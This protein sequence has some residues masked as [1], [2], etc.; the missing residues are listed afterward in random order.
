MIRRDEPIQ[1]MTLGNMR[2]NGVR[3]LYVTC[4]A[5]MGRGE[6]ILSSGAGPF[7]CLEG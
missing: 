3:G 4:S 5:I 7:A 2:R 1:V 6:T